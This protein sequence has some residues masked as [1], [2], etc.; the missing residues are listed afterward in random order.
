MVGTREREEEQ[1]HQ[2]HQPRW[3]EGGRRGR[4]GVRVCG[5]EQQRASHTR[6]PAHT[7]ATAGVR[8]RSGAALCV[9]THAE[10]EEGKEICA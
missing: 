5:G 8:V 9:A 3:G 4:G 7:Q 10:E 1:L 6:T 2:R